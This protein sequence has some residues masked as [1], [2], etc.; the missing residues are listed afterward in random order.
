MA[1]PMSKP[2]TVRQFD[3]AEANWKFQSE[4]L[5]AIRRLVF[6]LEQKVPQ[7]EEWDGQ[8]ED[9]WHWLA[10]DTEE[11][12]VGTVWLAWAV[13]HGSKINTDT[14]LH[15]FD[16]D[17]DAVRELTVAHALQGVIDRLG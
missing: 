3:V 8:D 7:E 11:K 4:A 12:P 6:V 15:H 14:K 17:R 9:A 1:S 13:R 16:G 5:K 10:T 2:L